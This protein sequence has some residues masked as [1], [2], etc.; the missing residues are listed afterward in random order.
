MQRD[1]AV[2]ATAHR[3]RDTTATRPSAEDRPERR[4]ERIHRER[5]SADRRRLE[6]REPLERL[7]EPGASAETIVS[8][9]TVS[10]TD[11]HA[12]PRVAS[13]NASITGSG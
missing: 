5:L 4:R 6:Q 12:S 1:G 8:P 10:R 9:S 13:P 7:R 11:A 3:D 2:H